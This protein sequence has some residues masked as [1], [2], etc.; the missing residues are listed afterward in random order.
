MGAKHI[1]HQIWS[2]T[3]QKNTKSEKKGEQVALPGQQHTSSTRE[4]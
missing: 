3:E 2:P 4:R 1:H